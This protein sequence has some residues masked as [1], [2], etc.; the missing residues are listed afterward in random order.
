VGGIQRLLDSQ[1]EAEA[2]HPND[3]HDI[4]M[5]GEIGQTFPDGV[6]KFGEAITE[7]FL[8]HYKVSRNGRGEAFTSDTTNARI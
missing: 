3:Q 8:D 5:A 7:L 1:L 4:S 6:P 2:A